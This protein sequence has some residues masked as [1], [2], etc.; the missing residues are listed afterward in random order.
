L[1]EVSQ[2]EALTFV[3]GNV[4]FG[5]ETHHIKEGVIIPSVLVIQQEIFGRGESDITGHPIVMTQSQVRGQVVQSI[6]HTLG[7]VIG[8]QRGLNVIA[9]LTIARNG[10]KGLPNGGI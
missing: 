3:Q 8:N 7:F 10:I 1:S 6:D 9:I 2:Q 4:V 5:N